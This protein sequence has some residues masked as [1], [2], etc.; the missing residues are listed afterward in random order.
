MHI[1]IVAFLGQKTGVDRLTLVSVSTGPHA[2]LLSGVLGSTAPVSSSHTAQPISNPGRVIWQWPCQTHCV[3]APIYFTF[4]YSVSKAHLFLQLASV[5]ST[6]LH[7]FSQLFNLCSHF[8]Y[9]QSC[10]FWVVHRRHEE[11]PHSRAILHAHFLEH[12][13]LWRD[14]ATL[15]LSARGLLAPITFPSPQTRGQAAPSRPVKRFR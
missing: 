5:L 15:Y 12:S 11:T 7:S 8:K 10:A 13:N 4:I 2:A 9:P 1:N 14:S 3:K 6:I